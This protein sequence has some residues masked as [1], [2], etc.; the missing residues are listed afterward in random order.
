MDIRKLKDKIFRYGALFLSLFIIVL[1][2][3][4]IFGLLIR[5]IPVLKENTLIDVIFKSQWHPLKGDFGLLYFIIGTF[6]VTLLS[7]LIAVP[8]C[9]LAS[10]YISEFINKRFKKIILTFVDILAGIPSVIYGVWGII[11]IIP[12]VKYVIAPI[13]N[14]QT[15]GYNILTASITL[16]VMISPVIIQFS[17]QIL[18]S[19]PIELREASLAL[20]A[21][22][23]ET[24]KYVVFK[25]AVPGIIAAV[26]LGISRALGETMA[27]LMLVGNSLKIP[28][29]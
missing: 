5:S 27:V 9:I 25:K 15:S 12:I 16:A 8:L 26:I 4:V 23:W 10:L 7:S 1:F 20:G 14:T 22:K 18:E 17:V 13:F 29:L 2:I 24:T 19:I 28:I 11:I 3:S 21:N 6:I